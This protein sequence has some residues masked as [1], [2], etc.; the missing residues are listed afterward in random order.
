MYRR[1]LKSSTRFLFVFICTI[2]AVAVLSR[3]SILTSQTKTNQETPTTY[4]AQ[5]DL[6]TE[7][8]VKVQAVVHKESNILPSVAAFLFLSLIPIVYVMFVW[9]KKKKNPDY[10]ASEARR[11]SPKQEITFSNTTFNSEYNRS[12]M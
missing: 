7:E 10:F 2:A 9:N 3:I 6:M 12:R 1:F 11:Y 4:A 8:N 5:N